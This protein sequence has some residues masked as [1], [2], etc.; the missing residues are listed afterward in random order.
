MRYTS[1]VIVL[2]LLCAN[3]KANYVTVSLVPV[4]NDV[5]SRIQNMPVGMQTL[6]G[7]P[8]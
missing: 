5:D 8:P 1:A 3:A 6:G 4:A 2:A 7:V